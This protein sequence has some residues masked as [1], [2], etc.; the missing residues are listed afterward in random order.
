MILPILVADGHDQSPTGA[1]N[2]MANAMAVK[3]LTLTVTSLVVSLQVLSPPSFSLFIPSLIQEEE[4]EKEE[5]EEEVKMRPRSR[6]DS[7]TNQNARFGELFMT[8]R[9]TGELLE[10]V[11]LVGVE[12]G[13]ATR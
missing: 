12:F 9:R 2:K 13:E 11:E 1:E 10:T 4:E 7:V 5:E 8:I 3:D 6:L